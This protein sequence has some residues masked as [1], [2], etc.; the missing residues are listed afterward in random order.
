MYEYN[1][2]N[3]RLAAAAILISLSALS[4]CGSGGGSSSDEAAAAAGTQI[5]GSPGVP[6]PTAD[7]QPTPIPTSGG[8]RAPTISGTAATVVSI[9][10]GYLFTPQAQDPDGNA[11][12]FGIRNA[13][14]WASFDA[15]TG[16]LSGTP[17]LADVGTFK[18]ILISVSDGTAAAELPAFTVTVIQSGSGAATLSWIPPTEKTDG[19]TLQDLAGYTI[20]YGRSQDTLDQAVRIDNPGINS[21]VLENLP[22][23]TYYFAVK[24]FTAGGSASEPSQLVSKNID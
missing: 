24:A 22:Q 7:P 3:S 14:S 6:G 4:G 17:S 11:L 10:T 15:R 9:D 23:G 5:P 8:N 16:K 2:K 18:D 13:P 19:T 20:V 21:F 12:I 1:A